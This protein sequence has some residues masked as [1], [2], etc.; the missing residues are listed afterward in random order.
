MAN[1]KNTFLHNQLIIYENKKKNYPLLLTQIKKLEIKGYV[2]TN[3]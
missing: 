1:H 3:S 2:T